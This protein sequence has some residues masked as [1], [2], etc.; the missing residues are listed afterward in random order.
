MSFRIRDRMHLTVSEHKH[1]ASKP[2]LPVSRRRCCARDRVMGVSCAA[3]AKR[4][5]AGPTR[6]LANYAQTHP[7]HLYNPPR[8][9]RRLRVF[10]SGKLRKRTGRKA[11][12]IMGEG[13]RQ[14]TESTIRKSKLLCRRFK[15]I[16]LARSSA[17]NR[18]IIYSRERRSI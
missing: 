10:S 2:Q 4:V 15:P 12:W 1:V 9:I 11:E 3:A 5:R 18:N 8:G 17:R 13:N 14:V 16:R 6:L 7:P